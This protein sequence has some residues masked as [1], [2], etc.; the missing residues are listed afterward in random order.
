MTKHY[1]LACLAFIALSACDQPAATTAPAATAE[2]AQTETQPTATGAVCWASKVVP[3]E[4]GYVMGQ[5]QVVQA[6]RAADGRVVTP[7]VY[8]NQ[9]VPKVVKP[10][11]EI[12]F[13][14]PCPDQ[15]TPQFIA[16]LQRALFARG[17]YKG[18]ING[19]MDKP[20]RD[21]ILH[22]QQRQG[23]NSDQLSMDTARDL[24]VLAILIPPK[25]DQ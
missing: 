2:P 10:R 16:T 11:S 9:P 15:Q 23:L 25:S 3:A 13:Q 14:T 18:R 22:Y 8:R 5:V 12:R 17:Y 4:Y 24:G 21:A 1:T 20:T 19:Q 6:E 7:P